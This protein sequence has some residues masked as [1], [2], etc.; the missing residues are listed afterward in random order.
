MYFNPTWYLVSQEETFLKA[1]Q[2]ALIADSFHEVTM[3]HPKRPFVRWSRVENRFATMYGDSYDVDV[4]IA[5][6]KFFV[7]AAIA[8]TGYFKKSD[9]GIILEW[10]DLRQRDLPWGIVLQFVRQAQHFLCRH[11]IDQM[12]LRGT[13][14]LYHL[15]LT[16][17]PN[18]SSMRD[19]VVWLHFCRGGS[20]I[21]Q[22][23]DGLL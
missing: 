15:L 14:H 1:R 7:T 12:C 13:R 20:S 2:T 22:T 16:I 23:K 21:V 10:D 18:L 6:P 4:V 19:R 5:K 3:F 17:W 8:V 11:R 9:S